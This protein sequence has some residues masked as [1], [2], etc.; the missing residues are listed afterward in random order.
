MLDRADVSGVS[1]SAFA[2]KAGVTGQRLSWWRQQLGRRRPRGGGEGESAPVFVELRAKRS[3]TVVDPRPLPTAG[4]ELEI[5]LAN[6]RSVI[7]PAS[8]DLKR[9][10]RL[11]AAVEGRA[12]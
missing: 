12:C 3:P 7:V 2:Q 9:L 10:E 6:G 11:L 1:D 4:E 8:V 5:R